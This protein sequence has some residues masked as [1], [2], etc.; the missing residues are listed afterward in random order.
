MS[1]EEKIKRVH[2]ACSVLKISKAD[3]RL[4][5]SE[6]WGVMSS[7]ALKDAELDDLLAHFRG[8]G[9]RH[10]QRGKLPAKAGRRKLT[11]DELLMQVLDEGGHVR[12][13]ADAIAK[14]IA[15]VDKYE[16]CTKQQRAA[17]IA[18]IIAQN[19]RKPKAESGRVRA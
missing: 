17:V 4:L 5:L 8:L 7:K 16:W 11:Q 13:Y 3:Y 10:W 15:R 12:S 19:A 18:N 1:R 2:M 9:W 6:R 14:K